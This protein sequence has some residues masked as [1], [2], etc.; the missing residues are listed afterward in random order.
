MVAQWHQ[1]ASWILVNIGSGNGLVLNRHQ[2]TTETN[3]DILS[4]GPFK[5]KLKWNF[6]GWSIFSLKKI[7][8][9]MLSAICQPFCSGF[10]VLIMSCIVFH[11][12]YTN[13]LVCKTGIWAHHYLKYQFFHR[14][15]SL[16]SNCFRSLLCCPSC[17]IRDHFEYAPS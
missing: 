14:C 12:L 10:N 5:N 7:H 2:A 15:L 6:C 16:A 8:W 13:Y 3:T 17:A 4:I 9:K 11:H 1:I